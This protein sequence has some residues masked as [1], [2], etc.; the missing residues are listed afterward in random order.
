MARVGADE[1]QRMTVID[2]DEAHTDPTP[3]GS[4]VEAITRPSPAR[5]STGWKRTVGQALTV[6]TALVALLSLFLFGGTAL[7]HNREQTALFKEFR[8]RAASI[9]LAPHYAT[10]EAGQITGVVPTPT[11]EPVARIRIPSIG[12]DEV[13]VEG[14]RSSETLRGPGHVRA[15]PLPGQFGNSVF[16]CRR[17]AGG[18]PCSDLDELRSGALIEVTTGRGSIRYAVTAVGRTK[19]ADGTIFNTLSSSDGKRRLNSLTLVTA[20]PALVASERLVVQAELQ[21]QPQGFTPGR[22]AVRNDELGLAGDDSAWLGV[23]LWLELLLVASVATVWMFKR[24]DRRA[25]WIVS[26]PVLVCS[27]WIVFEQFIRLLPA[28]L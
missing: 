1:G 23:F 12:L 28:A 26:V 22:I 3:D 18:A 2:L 21:D 7:V 14:S 27:M 16:V 17:S 15:T 6:F 13:A 9:A 10:N 19:A 11:G 4:T 8:S 20:A 25:A 5:S 24:W